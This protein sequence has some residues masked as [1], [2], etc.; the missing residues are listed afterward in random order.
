M[1]E[2]QSLAHVTLWSELNSK[3]SI[4]KHVH[5]VF[6]TAFIQLL[7]YS[8]LDCMLS[9]KAATVDVLRRAVENGTTC[10]RRTFPHLQMLLGCYKNGSWTFKNR[11]C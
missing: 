3:K 6:N 10:M 1:V 5:S 11:T 8:A 4:V 2:N 7:V 9:S